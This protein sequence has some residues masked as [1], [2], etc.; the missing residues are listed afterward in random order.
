MQKSGVESGYLRTQFWGHYEIL[1]IIQVR[2]SNIH[3]THIK[4]YYKIYAMCII[5]T[6]LFIL[7][8]VY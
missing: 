7:K 5:Q 2:H 1:Y 3:Y 8:C 6:N 4:V